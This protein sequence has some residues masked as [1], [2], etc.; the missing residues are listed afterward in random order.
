MIFLDIEVLFSDLIFFTFR[1]FRLL[2]HISRIK[3]FSYLELNAFL[4][5]FAKLRIIFV[6][7]V[8]SV[9]SSTCIM[10]APIGRICVKFYIAG[11]YEYMSRK[12]KFDYNRTKVWGTL[13]V[14]FI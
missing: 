9:C 5:A 10:S 1:I 11:C 8:T 7:F 12:S 2:Y 14:G 6:S 13:H 4:A 3:T